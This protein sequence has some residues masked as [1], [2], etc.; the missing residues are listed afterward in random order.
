MKRVVKLE[1]KG[2]IAVEE[3]GVPAFGKDE[4]LVK[5]H[6]SLISRGSELFARYVMPGP[7]DPER[8]G[9]SD[10][11]VVAAVGEAVRD[12]LIGDR[13]VAVAPHAE[14]VVRPAGTPDARII[15]LP[16]EGDAGRMSALPEISFE[17]ATFL[18]LLTSSVAWAQSACIQEG[19]T[20]IILGQGLVGNL[21]M[22]VSKDYKP[23]RVITIDALGL[24][25][26]LSERLGAEVVINCSK[27]DPVRAV[28][29]LTDGRGADVV[30]EC[31]GGDAGIRSF[32][33]AQDMV[34]TGGTIHLISLYQGGPL[35]LDSGKIMN[36]R[37]LAGIL[38]SEPR[39]ILAKRAI[40]HLLDGRVR[41]KEM[42]THRFPLTEAKKA[43][44]LLYE[45]P[46]E[47]LGVVFEY[48]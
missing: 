35:P 27:E 40:E 38:I 45:H 19:N 46:E 43:F 32:Q 13:V 18:P 17:E 44:D 8:M 3:I 22:Q 20:V 31:V 30:M 26:K 21:M 25:C 34:R 47:A 5:V 39:S 41:V 37:L 24:R 15:P 42:I 48:D 4:V 2:N 6:N 29:D 28:R 10:A 36:K 9:Y 23:G 14:Y 11:G 33:Q 1:G 12:I 16:A 7:V